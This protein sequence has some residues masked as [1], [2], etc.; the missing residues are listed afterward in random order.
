MATAQ[1]L[2]LAKFAL[3]TDLLKTEVLQ[4]CLR[5]LQ[6]LRGTGQKLTLLQLLVRKRVVPAEALISVTRAIEA[7]SFDCFRCNARYGFT[8]LAT[9]EQLACPKCRG[10]LTILREDGEAISERLTTGRRTGRHTTLV[11]NTAPI[12]ETKRDSGSGRLSASK[13]RAIVPGDPTPQTFGPYEILSE[14]GRGGMGVVYKARH[15][16]LD[17][18]VALKVL[19]AGDMASRTQVK[20]FQREAELAGKLKHPGIVAIHDIGQIGDR[21]YFTMDFVEGVPLNDKIKA[22]DLPLRQAVEIARDLARALAHAHTGG[23]IHRDVKPANIIIDSQGRPALT[24][25]GLAREADAESSVRLTREGAAVGTPFYM[26]PEQARGD[27]AKIG[28]GSDIYS[29]GVVLFEMLA[30]QL[31]FDAATQLDLTRKILSEDP[32]RLTSLEP[33]IDPDVETIVVKTLEKDPADRYLTADALADDLDRYLT[34]EPILARPATFYGRIRARLR[35][36]R[37]TLVPL[38]M[39]TIVVLTVAV[40]VALILYKLQKI[41]QLHAATELRQKQEAQLAKDKAARDAALLEASRRRDLAASSLKDAEAAFAEANGIPIEAAESFAERLR[42]TMDRATECLKND[43]KNARAFVLRGRA[44]E[45]A[46]RP[47]EA[48]KDFAQARELD[49]DGAAG[50][51]GAYREARLVARQHRDIAAA[52]AKYTVLG[53]QAG[54]TVW[55]FLANAAVQLLADTPRIDAALTELEAAKRLDPACPELYYLFALAYISDD[56]NVHPKEALDAL[57]SCLDNDKKNARAYGMR[58]RIYNGVRQDAKA[59]EDARKA[60]LIDPDE[61]AALVTRASMAAS[62]GQFSEATRDLRRVLDGEAPNEDPH[63]LLGSIQIYALDDKLDDARQAGLRAAELLPGS[64]DPYLALSRAYLSKDRVDLAVQT[65]RSGV[66]ALA[67][68][69]RAQSAVAASLLDLLLGASHFSE[70]EAFAKERIADSPDEPARK[71]AL[72]NVYAIRKED[73]DPDRAIAIYEELHRKVPTFYDAYSSHIRLLMDL[74]RAKDVDDLI[75]RLVEAQATD[76]AAWGVAAAA[77]ALIDKK[78]AAFAAAQKAVDLD[79]SGVASNARLARFELAAHDFPAAARYARIA[80]DRDRANPR[81]LT[82]LGI[83]SMEQKGPSQEALDF[84]QAALEADPGEQDA[85]YYAGLLMYGSNKPQIALQV[86]ETAIRKI[87]GREAPGQ[88]LEIA[89]ISYLAINKYPQA[90]RALLG[91][92]AQD[93]QN[94][95][96]HTALGETYWRENDAT[97]ARAEVERALAIDAT[98]EPARKLKVILEK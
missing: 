93:P 50:G 42:A 30:F 56:N 81:A 45:Y 74:H 28:P 60:L 82:V 26:S 16:A 79:P 94:P 70:A 86:V 3:K 71:L 48:L 63:V 89:G 10:P 84:F 32:P 24:D 8:A 25:F 96:L 23:V 67:R 55:R 2:L 78:Q 19:I 34:G 12:Q 88:L 29:L 83:V 92:I 11:A 40:G 95:K 69:V 65:L 6:E 4:E 80:L 66:T 44:L 97:K 36:H 7:T 31:P 33:A 54:S 37:R 47:D 41:E 5:E 73:Q 38:V 57:Q 21:H 61:S 9:S 46:K 20:R 62:H 1:D 43:P 35:R 52:R 14:L 18:I 75:Q 77:Y 68:D 58:A 91:A 85:A 87:G 72:A 76:P 59:E 39:V 51:E 13:L 98:Y 49:P 90:E 22:H 27:R 15:P 53:S 64:P 17:R